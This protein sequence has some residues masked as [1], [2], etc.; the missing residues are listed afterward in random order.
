MLVRRPARKRRDNLRLVSALLGFV[1]QRHTVGRSSPDHWRRKDPGCRLTAGWARSSRRRMAHA[2]I[3]RKNPVLTA[4][5]LINGHGP[6]LAEIGPL[7]K[8]GLIHAYFE[9]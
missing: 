2:L 5:V 9:L 4:P 1:D 6:P 8:K 3:Q 7:R